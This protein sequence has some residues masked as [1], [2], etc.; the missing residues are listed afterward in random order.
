MLEWYLQWV[1]QIQQGFGIKRYGM[2][3]I[4]RLAYLGVLMGKELII[5]SPSA[6]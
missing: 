1:P 5:G 4:T 6:I 2:I 3:S